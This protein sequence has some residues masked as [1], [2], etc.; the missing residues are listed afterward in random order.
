MI[1][2]IS[3]VP[4]VTELIVALG[5][6]PWL[7][8]RTGF[9]IH[10]EQALSAIPKIGGTK[11]INLPKLKRLLPT[12]VVVNVDENRLET[13]EALREF[14]A[15]VV[16]THPCGPL[17]N[18]ALLDQLTAVFADEVSTQQP[19]VDARARA[20]DLAAALTAELAACEGQVWPARRALY[21]I[22]RDPWMT[23]A[24]DT[25]IAR[26]LA[27]VGWS[28]WPPQDGGHAGAARYPVVTGA[29]PWL[30][31]IDDVLLSSE[32]YRFGPEHVAQ[33]QALCPNARVSLVDGEL[34]SWY[35]PRAARGLA[36]LRGL[37]EPDVPASPP[38]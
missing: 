30:A 16:V 31:E 22:W 37:R 33:A 26:M 2:I 7:V 10:P 29:E 32:P 3:L 5:L 4:S 27:Q 23:V 8:G 15:N 11:D 36:Y 12:H 20:N 18:F 34:I 19:S 35:G 13:V 25:Y 24:R 14:V 38:R 1:R 6:A 21:L 9:C 28:T 17:D